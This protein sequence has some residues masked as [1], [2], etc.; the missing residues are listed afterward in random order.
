MSHIFAELQGG[1]TVE[2]VTP[3]DIRQAIS[4]RASDDDLSILIFAARIDLET[5][6]GLCIAEARWNVPEKQL[7]RFPG[8]V[9][10]RS[11]G[12]VDVLC[13]YTAETL[14]AELRRAIYALVAWALANRGTGYPYARP[15]PR[16]KFRH[17]RN[18]FLPAS[19]KAA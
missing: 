6:T 9:I 8:R 1:S 10:D 14:P 3:A 12:G 5:D 13:G 4:T 16:P 11:N 19:Q 15:T 2:P 7:P 18:R 17:F